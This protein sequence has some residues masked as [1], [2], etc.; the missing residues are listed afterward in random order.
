MIAKRY[1]VD[2]AMAETDSKSPSEALRKLKAST[3]KRYN[4]I[5]HVGAK[6]RAKEARKAAKKA[7]VA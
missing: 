5:P 3:S 7:A 4:Y 1:T 6:Q 2:E